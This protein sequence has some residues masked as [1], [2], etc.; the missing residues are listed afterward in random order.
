MT[1]TTTTTTTRVDDAGDVDDDV[2]GRGLRTALP[3]L[4]RNASLISIWIPNC[5]S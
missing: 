1:N 5:A 3:D 2:D 4:P